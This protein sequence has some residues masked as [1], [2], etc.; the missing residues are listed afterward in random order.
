MRA[1]TSIHTHYCEARKQA[2]S[3]M[4]LAGAWKFLINVV[5]G[6]RL[7]IDDWMKKP[8]RRIFGDYEIFAETTATTV[9]WKVPLFNEVF[10]IITIR[11][12][13]ARSS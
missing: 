8:Y 2:Q 4:V 13:K 7:T 12:G 5:G 1:H 9:A 6:E 10:L 11:T 3:N